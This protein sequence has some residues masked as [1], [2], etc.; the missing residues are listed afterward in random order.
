MN[1]PPKLIRYIELVSI[2]EKN[3]SINTFGKPTDHF[4]EVVSGDSAENFSLLNHVAQLNT[5]VNITLYWS[6]VSIINNLQLK[7]SSEHD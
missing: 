3:Y 4:S 6:S 2:K 7:N 5:N 1:G